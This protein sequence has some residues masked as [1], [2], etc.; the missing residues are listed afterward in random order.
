MTPELEPIARVSLGHFPTPLERLDRL[1]E[2]LG[3]PEIWI[4]RD[5]CTGLAFGG[6]K[7]RKLEYL[8]ADAR[9]Q[10]ADAMITFGAVQSNHVRQTIAAC[11]KH[12]LECHAILADIV[13]YQDPAYRQSGNLFLDHMSTA[14]LHVVPPG[15][16]ATATFKAIL[17]DLET[18]AKTPYIVPAGG[19]S[20][21][22]A[23]A[24]V[25]AAFELRQQC[26][27]LGLTFDAILHASATGGTQVGLTVGQ[28]NIDAATKVWGVN[29]YDVDEAAF[30]GKLHAFAAEAADAWK[31]EKTPALNI[32][33][34]YVGDGYG[35]PT[36]GMIE[37]V[38]KTFQLEGILLDPVYT[39]K[40]MAALFDQCRKGQHAA[41]DKILFVHTGGAPGLFAYQ[42]TFT[43]RPASD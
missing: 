8:I 21:V 19:S 40:A 13:P 9:A 43:N 14:H 37:A 42:D 1:S 24:Y 12:N 16:D 20:T 26:T 11:A 5:D 32:V 4:K 33:H 30:D 27:E 18:Q 38:R 10:N 15:G 39:G 31:L 35:V 41:T 36:D 2:F 34:G 23:M 22:G 28:N 29:V 17:A 3:G 7:T 6:N 25:L